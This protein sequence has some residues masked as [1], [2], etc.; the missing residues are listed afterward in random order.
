MSKITKL[1]FTDDEMEQI[2]TVAGD[3]PVATYIKRLTLSHIRLLGYRAEGELAE[4]TPEQ[5]ADV[6][7]YLN[8]NREI[9]EDLAAALPG[10]Q[11]TKLDR[12]DWLIKHTG[13]KI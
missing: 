1:T 13:Y 2:K 3:V 7:Q 8:E 6:T 9:A 5:W 10:N 4:L 12:V 11:Y